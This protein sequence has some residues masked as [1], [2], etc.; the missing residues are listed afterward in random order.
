MVSF[1]FSNNCSGS[2]TSYQSITIMSAIELKH[3]VL[4]ENINQS[5]R[6]IA[7]SAIAFHL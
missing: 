2:S 7:L 5:I 6:N 3:P 4:S 1:I